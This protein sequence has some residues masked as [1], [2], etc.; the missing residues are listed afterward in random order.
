MVL[1]SGIGSWPGTDIRDAL[2]VVRDALTEAP[3]GVTTLPYLPELPAR[4]PGA[5]M[6][7][8]SAGL[9]VDLPVDM[10]PQ[11]WRLVDRPGRDAERTTSLWRQDLDEL[12]EAFDGWSGP[13]KLQVT[14]PWTLAAALWLPLGDRVLSDA[15]ATR[16]LAESLAEGVRAHVTE[17]A[18]LLPGTSLTLQ[19]DEPSLPAVLAG[20]VRSD[21]GYRVLP[22]PDA[23]QAEH[24]LGTV[25]TAARDAG[26]ATAVHCC[27]GD[28]PVA[29]LRGAGAEA[30]ALDVAT[31]STRDWDAVAEAVEAGTTLW[32]GALSTSRPTAYGQV[33]ETISTRWHELGLSP[34]SLADL[35]VTP[36]CGLAGT[37]PDAARAI[38]R[39]TV[40][41]ARALAEVAVR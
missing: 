39:A 8:R 40:E 35:G 11:G 10:P 13:L 27:A 29:L 19:V 37:T 6:V 41:S 15:G 14:G 18:R 23:S 32:A 3:D 26:A 30:L 2:R 28:P 34:A 33:V 22:A 17:V 5:D 9:L 31:L 21:S 38:T 4:G 36:A 1:A 20:H 7:G 25:L 24:V 16:D 12:A